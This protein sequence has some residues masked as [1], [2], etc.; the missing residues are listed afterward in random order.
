MDRRERERER[1]R[2]G[3]GERESQGPGMS[4]GK[5]TKTWLIENSRGR[6]L[7]PGGKNENGTE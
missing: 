2:G 7:D 1:E 5:S 4:R 6:K 3:G